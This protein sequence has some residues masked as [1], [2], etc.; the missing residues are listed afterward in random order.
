MLFGFHS[1]STHELDHHRWNKWLSQPLLLHLSLQFP[2]YSI[3]KLNASLQLLHCSR[4]ETKEL[5]SQES[6]T[7][8]YCSVCLILPR[9]K[10]NVKERQHY[11][12]KHCRH[13]DTVVN[14]THFRQFPCLVGPPHSDQIIGRGEKFGPSKPHS[15][16]DTGKMKIPLSVMSVFFSQRHQ[17]RGA[18]AVSALLILE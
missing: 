11:C 14:T 12:S 16:S 3:V 9:S 1:R 10:I 18:F 8:R 17:V 4:E 5:V 6:M 2:F 13:T 15:V 7:M